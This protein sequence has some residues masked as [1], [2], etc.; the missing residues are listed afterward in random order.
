MNPND[1]PSSLAEVAHNRALRLRSIGYSLSATIFAEVWHASTT[2]E[3]EQLISF[4]EDYDKDAVKEWIRDHSALKL[5][6]WPLKR[7]AKEA[8]HRGFNRATSKMKQE[9]IEELINANKS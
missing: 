8:T 2:S 4:V 7:L 5:E 9:L 1:S 6:D 3:R